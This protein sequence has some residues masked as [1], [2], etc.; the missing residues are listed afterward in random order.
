MVWICESLRPGMAVRPCA[1]TTSVAGPR[2]RRI[3]SLLPAE[4]IRP[5][6]IATAATNAG[7]LFV[8]IFAFRG[9]RLFHFALFVGGHCDS[10][11]LF[12]SCYA[13]ASGG[14]ARRRLFAAQSI[15]E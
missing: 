10:S 14:A 7:V 9:D 4:L 1:S 15:L 11:V 8:A 13:Y 12:A 2:C 5:P 3:S 6:C